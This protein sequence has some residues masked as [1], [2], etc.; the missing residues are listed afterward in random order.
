MI[1]L[2]LIVAAIAAAYYVFCRMVG[3]MVAWLVLKLVKPP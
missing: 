3:R 1:Q 2:A